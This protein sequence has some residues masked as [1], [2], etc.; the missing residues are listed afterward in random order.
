MFRIVSTAVLLSLAVSAAEAQDGATLYAT[1]CSMCHDGGVVRAPSR[2]ALSELTPERIVASLGTGVMRVQGADRT[3]DERTAIAVFL[4]GKPLGTFKAA[5]T[6]LCSSA[7]QPA[8]AASESA[9]NGWSTSTDND[10]YQRDAGLRAADVPRLKL[11]WAFGFPGDTSAAVQ[12]S[13]VGGRVLVGSTS[14]RVYSLSLASGCAFWTFDADTQVRTAIVTGAPKAGGPL[15]V[16]F[17]DVAGNVYSVD[18]TRGTVRWKVKVDEHPV[19]RIT[20]TPKLFDGRLYVAVSSLEEIAGADPHYPCCT[21]RGSLVAL[22]ADTGRQI[23]HSYTIPDPP[24]ATTK[25]KIGTQ[26]YAPSGAAVWGSP[27]IDTARRRIYVGTGDS[28][29]EPAAATSDAI[30]AFDL[31]TGALKWASQVTTGDAFNLGCAG[32]DASNCPSK[33]GP[34]H[35]FGAPPILVTLGSGQRRLIASQKSGAVHALDPETGR[36]LWSRRIGPGG[37]LGGIEW[38]AAADGRAVYV[39]LSG[40]LLKPATGA[41]PIVIGQTVLDPDAGGG[42]FA[43]RL[44]DGE[45]I[46]S[47]PPASCA[48]RTLCSPAQSAAISAIDGAVFSG[49]VDGHLRAYAASQGQV[50][51]DFDT[52]REF[53]TVNHVKAAGGSIDVGGPAIAEGVV[54]TTSGYPPFGGRPGNVLLA[55]SVDGK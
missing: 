11:K 14:G 33:P 18:A 1:Y 52:A 40:Q 27:A 32:A 25:N 15:A 37:V 53:D 28:Y 55:F 51:W 36:V 2:K 10:R 35:D 22:D 50:I 29:S 42:L 4:T 34:D 5:V 3:P 26:M 12:P 47:A 49:S 39:A 21:F 19:A 9:W 45:T 38:G 30:V 23:W 6:P 46:W 43:L 31:D 24:I 41:G 7:A 16:F 20:A 8:T 44:T 13:I 48:G 54:V 17:G